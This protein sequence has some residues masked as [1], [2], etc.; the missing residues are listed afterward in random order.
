MIT[1][2][3]PTLTHRADDSRA[4]EFVR[5]TLVQHNVRQDVLALLM[6]RCRFTVKDWGNTAG[7]GVCHWA[8]PPK[9]IHVQLNG[10][11]AEACIHETAHAFRVVL[12][13]EFPKAWAAIERALI[14]AFLFEEA[15]PLTEYPRIRQLA[16][17]YRW[18]VDEWPGMWNAEAQAWRVSE[19]WAGFASASMGDLSLYPPT[20]RDVYRVFYA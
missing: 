16:R 9:R 1:V 5:R 19:I 7:G 13:T 3:L 10:A 17:D 2:N 4:R 12:V 11:Q 15:Q 8:E 14:A 18:G 6:P 20:L